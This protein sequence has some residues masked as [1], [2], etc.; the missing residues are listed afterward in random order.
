M[1]NLEK[2]EETAKNQL[3]IFNKKEA[4]IDKSLKIIYITN[5]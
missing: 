1:I 4:G 2:L 3:K 5:V